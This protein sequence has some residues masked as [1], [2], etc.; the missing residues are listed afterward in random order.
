MQK[1]DGKIVPEEAAKKDGIS[2]YVWMICVMESSFK[3]VHKT[4]VTFLL[5]KTFLFFFE[6]KYLFS[7]SWKRFFSKILRIQLPRVF[8]SL[9]RQIEKHRYGKNVDISEC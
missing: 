6:Q 3:I 5:S 2:E 1:S 8:F 4:K 9:P 7:Y